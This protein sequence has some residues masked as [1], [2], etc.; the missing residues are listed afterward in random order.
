V[1]AKPHNLVLLPILAAVMMFAI[2]IGGCNEKP[3]G[4]QSK[5]EDLAQKAPASST[6]STKTATDKN[7]LKNAATTSTT[8]VTPVVQEQTKP[9]GKNDKIILF[10]TAH[11]E[12]FNLNDTKQMGCT[13]MRDLFTG[14]GYT[15]ETNKKLFNDGVFDGVDAVV[16]AGPMSKPNPQEIESL[17]RYIEKGGDLLI[18]VHVSYFI[19]DLTNALGL[20]LSTGVLGQQSESFEGQ[21]KNFIARGVSKHTVTDGVKGIAVRGT[22]ALQPLP[23]NTNNASTVVSTSSDS[24]VDVTS[25][26]IYDIGEPR[27][28]YGIVGVSTVGKGKVIVIGDD[29]VFTNFTIDIADNRMLCENIVEWF[30]S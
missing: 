6:S 11:A 9:R 26:D 8:A 12:I 15:I 10:D 27:G 19:S 2:I 22:W 4:G 23:G 24:W 5:N 7:G 28:A 18:T 3:L 25:N 29:A 14:K 13:A 17:M 16:I 1:S 21:V 30:D 20:Q